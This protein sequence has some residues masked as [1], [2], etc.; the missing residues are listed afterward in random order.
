[1]SHEFPWNTEFVQEFE[2]FYGIRLEH[3]WFLS[4]RQGSVV[5]LSSAAVGGLIP[6]TTSAPYYG[7]DVFT[8]L[9]SVMTS[10]LMK[11]ITSNYAF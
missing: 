2:H 4:Q 1:M 8:R 9:S 6:L 3:N 5:E 7:A 11:C 10:N